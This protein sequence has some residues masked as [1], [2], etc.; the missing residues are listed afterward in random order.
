METSLSA[1]FLLMDS[2]S[3]TDYLVSW[4]LKCCWSPYQPHPKSNP[5]FLNEWGENFE[6]EFCDN[7]ENKLNR[8]GEGGGS[9][10]CIAPSVT[11]HAFFRRSDILLTFNRRQVMHSRFFI[12]PF[13]EVACKA[14]FLIQNHSQEQGEA[15]IFN[16]SQQCFGHM[17]HFRVY[18]Y[19]F[20][21]VFFN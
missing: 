9:M 14:I 12:V 16:H 3:N 5:F 13:A 18:N 11:L 17:L 7:I 6:F 20:Y 8:G 10:P 21:S 4:Q 2:V 1:L 19:K 15:L